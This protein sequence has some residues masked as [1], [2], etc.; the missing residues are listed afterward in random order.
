M[1]RSSSFCTLEGYETF[2]YIRK[3]FTQ[4]LYISDRGSTN[5]ESHIFNIIFNIIVINSPIY[6]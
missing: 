1:Q 3:E 6:K 2:S 4:F 5:T